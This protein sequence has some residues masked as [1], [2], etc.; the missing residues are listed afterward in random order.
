MKKTTIIATALSLAATATAV[1]AAPEAGMHGS[2][3][4]E[5]MTKSIITVCE[6][7]GR[8]TTGQL[9]YAGGGSSLGAK[10]MANLTQDIAPM[11]R[12]LKSSDFCRSR[13]ELAPTA[14]GRVVGLDGIAVMTDMDGTTECAGDFV[15]YRPS[16]CFGVYDGNDDGQVTCRAGECT[17]SG[18]STQYC[19]QDWKD[20][21]RIIY[22]G[23]TKSAGSSIANQDCNSDVRHSLANNW[24]AMFEGTETCVSAA[25]QR[26]QR[27]FRRGDLSGTTDTFLSL[28]DLPS[29]R[30]G[31]QKAVKPFCNGSDTEDLD[32]VRVRCAN[33]EQVCTLQNNAPRMVCTVGASPDVCALGENNGT[34]VDDDGAGPAPGRCREVCTADAQC[35]PNGFCDAAA[36]ICKVLP[37]ADQVATVGM[38]A[39][40]G[41]ARGPDRLGRRTGCWGLGL[42]QAVVVPE[43]PTNPEP[44]STIYPTTSCVSGRFKL[45][46]AIQAIIPPTNFLFECPYCSDIT[47]PG[48]CNIAGQCLI[49]TTSQASGDLPSCLNGRTSVPTFCPTCDGRA[50]NLWT[51]KATGVVAGRSDLLQ[52]GAGRF[53]AALTQEGDDCEAGE[54]GCTP[55][56]HKMSGW[57]SGTGS[58]LAPR[59]ANYRIA[60]GAQGSGNAVCNS[61]ISSTL[62][63]GCVVGSLDCSIG[64]AGREAGNPS[65]RVDGAQWVGLI[66]SDGSTIT[67]PTAPAIEALINGGNRYQLARKLYLNTLVGFENLTT[68]STATNPDRGEE[69]ALAE[70]GYCYGDATTVANAAVASG[71]LANPRGLTCESFSESSCDAFTCATTTDCGTL[72]TCTGGICVQT[73]DDNS[74]C[75]LG[76]TCDTVAGTCKFAPS[77]NTNSCLNGD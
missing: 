13:G 49:P 76:R 26:L 4:L 52:D 29:F 24:S 11:S 40:S 66:G 61:Q 71:F 25:C 60:S 69:L 51:W 50:W 65:P 15:E 43:Y 23:M 12:W 21:L 16:M 54:A 3:T 30:S 18:A 7:A 72:G 47:Q 55:R 58:T 34:C 74:D 10:D 22:S 68:G 46:P 62:L 28:L 45:K 42:L 39:P 38:V 19:F 67:E 41:A 5:H 63:I 59:P 44:A 73:C 31:D 2:D 53:Q 56:N 35:G 14:E 57:P 64:Y 75:T 9:V 48:R 36:G 17:G 20:A 27:V 8:L 37:C 33:N 77:G 6:A 1:G 70:R 32:P